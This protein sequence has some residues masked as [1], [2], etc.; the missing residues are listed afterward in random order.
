MHLLSCG[1]YLA[2]ALWALSWIRLVSQCPLGRLPN[3]PSWC[4]NTAYRLGPTDRKKEQESQHEIGVTWFI[5]CAGAYPSLHMCFK[6][7]FG[8]SA[9]LKTLTS[10]NKE[11]RPP[12]SQVFQAIPGRQS[13]FT[14]RT[15]KYYMVSSANVT[16]QMQNIG[17]NLQ[18]LPVSNL[19]ALAVSIRQGKTIP[20]RRLV[21]PDSEG[22]YGRHLA[23]NLGWVGG[24]TECYPYCEGNQNVPLRVCRTLWVLALVFL[25]PPALSFYKL[26]LWA[27]CCEPSSWATNC[28][29]LCVH[30]FFLSPT[31]AMLCTSRHAARSLVRVQIGLL[32]DFPVF[33]GGSVLGFLL[34]SFRARAARLGKFWVDQKHAGACMRS[35]AKSGE[36]WR[37]QCNIHQNTPPP[38]HSPEFRRRPPPHSPEFRW[39]CLGYAC[40]VCSMRPRRGSWYVGQQWCISDCTIRVHHLWQ[41]IEWNFLEKSLSIPYCLSSYYSSMRCSPLWFFP[42][43]SLSAWIQGRAFAH[44]GSPPPSPFA[45]FNAAWQP[46]C[47][48]VQ[49]VWP[50]DE[51]SLSMSGPQN[52]YKMQGGPGSVR[53]WSRVERFERFR[54][55]WFWW[56]LC[57]KAFLRVSAQFKGMVRFLFRF[58]FLKNSSDGSGSNFGSWKNG[59]DGSGFQFGSCAILKIT[60]NSP[61]GIMFVTI[62]V[63]NWCCVPN[64]TRP[65][66]EAEGHQ[67]HGEF[68]SQQADSCTVLQF[69]RKWVKK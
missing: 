30:V 46:R 61:Q 44:W 20:N 14:S 53:L 45:C 25:V 23:L 66:P 9:P 62:S 56:F 12:F 41:N 32:V 17:K 3:S 50:Q 7:M 68:W 38:S 69:Q 40:V 1:W 16:A 49:R 4:F 57:G 47:D 6:G 39:R 28:V 18:Q 2:G 64:C 10:L 29:V 42:F 27:G 37:T 51:K 54:I 22:W 59:S 60:I 31:P 55:F 65:P 43:L 21:S 58:R 15:S 24:L 19:S 63:S 26:I 35:L 34:C 36:V 67:N 52:P 5:A 48:L 8:W 33:A 11:V 13:K